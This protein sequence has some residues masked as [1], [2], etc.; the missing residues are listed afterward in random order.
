MALIFGDPD[1]DLPVINFRTIHRSD[2]PVGTC[3]I[4]IRW[5]LS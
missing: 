2:G 4:V 1:A 3:L 5:V